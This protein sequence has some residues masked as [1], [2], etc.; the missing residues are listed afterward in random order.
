MERKT[1]IIGCIYV[2]L[3]FIVYGCTANYRINYANQSAEPDIYCL[4]NETELVLKITSPV[5]EDKGYIPARYT[6]NSR[7][8][9]PPLRFIGIPKN[10]KSLA[11][12]VDDPDAP[13]GT[14]SHWVV[15]NIPIVSRIEENS[16]PKGAVQGVNDFKKNNYSGPC[17]PSGTHRYSFRLYALD[18]ILDLNESAAKNDIE[19]AMLGHII[20][21]SEL[22]GL[23]T[24]KEQTK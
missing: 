3:I 16:V 14:W 17:P 22:T 1:A 15:W 20:E 24:K 12:I 10:A 7:N 19:E 13:A 9:N 2:F 6:C 21:K 4:K 23:Y 8:I 5:F 11:L 18:T